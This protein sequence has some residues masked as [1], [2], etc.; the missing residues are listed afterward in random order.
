MKSLAVL[1]ALILGS[2]S[3]A[4][5]NTVCVIRTI[6][7]YR[8]QIDL[9][10]RLDK[11][12]HCALS[13]ILAIQCGPAESWVMGVGKEIADLFDGGDPDVKDLRADHIGI[14]MVRRGYARDLQACST[15]C[16]RIFPD[17]QPKI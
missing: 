17:P 5:T 9:P 16:L 6:K 7:Q 12:K 10:Q 4:E 14:Q 1:L 2:S 8:P 11:F 13:C 15:Q 3:F